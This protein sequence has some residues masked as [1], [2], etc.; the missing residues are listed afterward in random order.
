MK[1][2]AYK[3]YKPSGVEWLEQ[4]PATWTMKRLKYVANRSEVKVDAD[5][6]NPLPYIGL[7]HVESWTGRLLPLDEE[8]VPTGISNWHQGAGMATAMTHLCRSRSG[9]GCPP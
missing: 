4:L 7:E 6:D 1:L 2:T 8:L 3:S 5:E 9:T